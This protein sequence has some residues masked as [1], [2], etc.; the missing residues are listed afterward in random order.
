MT[1]HRAHLGAA[2]LA[3]HG[4]LNALRNMLGHMQMSLE[5]SG[6]K[7]SYDRGYDESTG[8]VSASTAGAGQPRMTYTKEEEDLL[9]V[10]LEKYLERAGVM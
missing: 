8:L 3:W 6:A 7:P 4:A 5:V 10:V 9:P 1:S 2:P